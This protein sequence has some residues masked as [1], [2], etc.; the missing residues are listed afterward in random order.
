V[1]SWRGRKWSNLL[2]CIVIYAFLTP[3]AGAADTQPCVMKMGWDLWPPYQYIDESG[4]LTGFDIDFISAIGKL[5]DCEVV[6]QEVNWARG[7]VDLENGNLDLIPNANFT[8]ERSVW[9][10]Y[11]EPYRDS[12]IVMYI[13]KGEL[14]LYPYQS[15]KDIAGTEFRLGVGRGVVYSDEFSML[16][17]NPEFRERLQYIP[18]SEMQQYEMLQ[19]GRIYGILRSITALK[20]LHDSFGQGFNLEIHP[21]PVVSARQHVIFS[22]KSVSAEKVERFNE[23]L[24]TIQKNGLLDRLAANYFQ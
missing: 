20:S 3:S 21:M 9:A 6:Y 16:Q 8:E 24:R 22:K 15:L 10:H 23:S 14:E 19:A 18:T 11:S 2:L 4:K 12:S 1:N 7:L 5:M 13:R 17:K